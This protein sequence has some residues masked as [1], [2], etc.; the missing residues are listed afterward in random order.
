[1]EEVKKVKEEYLEKLR[2][3][4][5]MYHSKNT[6]F[7]VV[8]MYS[9]HIREFTNLVEKYFELERDYKLLTIS[10]DV[11]REEYD[12]LAKEKKKVEDDLQALL[13]IEHTVR[14][15]F[16]LPSFEDYQS[17]IGLSMIPTKQ[18]SENDPINPEYYNDTKITPF[19][20]IDDWGLDF[21]LGSAMKYIKRAGKKEGNSTVQ[22]LL[23]VK[24]Y[25][26]KEIELVDKEVNQCR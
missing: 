12:I 11:I 22:D 7:E 15:A 14:E 6:S 20:V 18:V 16:G 3:M 2:F 26:E 1:M 23:K 24:R 19:D 21:Y 13:N 8:K 4:E 25:I 9:D 5:S 10:N 17:A